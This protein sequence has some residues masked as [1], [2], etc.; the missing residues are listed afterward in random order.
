MLGYR[1]QIVRERLA[2]LYEVLANLFVSWIVWTD[3]QLYEKFR[4]KWLQ[5]ASK[6]AKSHRKFDRPHM[7]SY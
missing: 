4:L 7:T 1:E 6:V 2:Q 3:V 5:Q